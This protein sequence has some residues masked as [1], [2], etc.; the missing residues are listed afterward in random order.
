MTISA[1]QFLTNHRL[2][3]SDIDINDLVRIFTDDMNLGLEGKEGALRMIPT[4]IEAENDFI[5]DTPERT[6]FSFKT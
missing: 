3:S 1:N 6:L 4:Y 2:R 5:T